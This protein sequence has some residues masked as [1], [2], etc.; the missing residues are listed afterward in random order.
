MYEAEVK[1]MRGFTEVG[2]LHHPQVALASEGALGH[3]GHRGDQGFTVHVG[4]A[5]SSLVLHHEV[6]E[7]GLAE[8]QGPA[9]GNQ[10][11]RETGRPHGAA[12]SEPAEQEKMVQRFGMDLFTEQFVMSIKV[13]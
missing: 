8:G 1:I 7:A 2:A 9:G 6:Q 12:S 10:E 11:Q 5:G 3:C 4:Q 13:T